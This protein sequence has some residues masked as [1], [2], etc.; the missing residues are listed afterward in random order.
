MRTM[1]DSINIENAVQAI[2]RDQL[3]LKNRQI[4]GS[5]ALE[6]VLNQSEDAYDQT[7][8]V[9][10]DYRCGGVVYIV[11]EKQERAYAELIVKIYKAG[12]RRVVG[13]GHYYDAYYA[14]R[15]S[16]FDVD[17]GAVNYKILPFYFE[18]TNNSTPANFS[19]KFIV[20][21]TDTGE[22]SSALNAFQLVY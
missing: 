1:P 12:T 19:F 7:V 20:P 16:P 2:R 10:A 4:V 17:I 3:Q 18:L 15:Q 21:S 6:I 11:C 13:Q 14:K 9:P 8:Y 22:V 5:N